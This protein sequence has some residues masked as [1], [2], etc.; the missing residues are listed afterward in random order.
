MT[1]VTN[2]ITRYD[3]SNAVREDLANVIYNIAPVG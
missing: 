3:E 1:L 2:A